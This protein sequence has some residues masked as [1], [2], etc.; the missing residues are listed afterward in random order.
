M[1]EEILSQ[2][3]EPEP[4]VPTPAELDEMF[5]AMD[6]SVWV[7][8]DKIANGPSEGQTQLQCNKEVDRNVNYLEIMLSKPYIQDAGRSLTS[9]ENAI[10]DGKAYIESHGGLA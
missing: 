3:T 10:V 2:I 5:K 6:D 9:Y 4:W 8:N 7:I 1:S